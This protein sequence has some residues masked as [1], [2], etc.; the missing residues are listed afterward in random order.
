MANASPTDGGVVVEGRG[1][2]RPGVSVKLEEG[3]EIARLQ[4]LCES[5]EEMQEVHDALDFGCAYRGNLS[6]CPNLYRVQTVVEAVASAL[7]S[8]FLRL[9][10]SASCPLLGAAIYLAPSFQLPISPFEP[11]FSPALRL[12]AYPFLPSQPFDVLLSLPAFL[13]QKH[14]LRYNQRECQ[15][16]EPSC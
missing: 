16:P 13:C 5:C 2:V 9:F 12:F 10:L 6:L 7:S 14:L 8:S 15:V 11:A 4:G 1:N 3:M